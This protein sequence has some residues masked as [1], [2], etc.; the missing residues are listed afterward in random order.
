MTAPAV[1][2][3]AEKGVASEWTLY[4]WDAPDGTSW[5]VRPETHPEHGRRADRR[6]GWAI[7]QEDRWGGY[8]IVATAAR[9]RDARR[10][11]GDP[12]WRARHG[13]NDPKVN[14]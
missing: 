3:R 4:E 2:R 14:L 8:V 5:A 9:L 10:H 1:L 6:F 7:M 13:L 12:G 11:L